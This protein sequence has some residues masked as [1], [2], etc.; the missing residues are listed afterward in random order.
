[1]AGLKTIALSFWLLAAAEEKPVPRAEPSASAPLGQLLEW[2]SSRGKPYW[3]RLPRKLDRKRPPNLLLMLHGTGLKWGWA[4]WNYPIAAGGFRGEDI[5]VAPEAMTPGQGDTFN[6]VQGGA[7]GEQLAELIGFFKRQLPV[8]KVYLYGHSQGAFFAYWFA[9][10]HPELVDGIVAHAGNVLAVKHTALA[11]QKVAIGILHA[12]AD[13]VVPVDCA[14]RSEKI[15]REEGYRRVKLEV[16]EGLT[17][18]SGHWPLPKQVGEMLSWLD[19]VTAD[20]PALALLSALQVL[21]Q[22]EPDL[23][24]VVESVKR[25]GL[26]LKAPRP[27]DPPDLLEK[28]EALKKLLDQAAHEHAEAIQAEAGAAKTEAPFGCWAGHFL[29][30]DRALGTLPAW[31]KAASG[32]RR[33]AASEEKGVA[34]ALGLLEQAGLKAL[35]EGLKALEQGFLASRYE[36]LLVR[37]ERLAGDSSLKAEERKRTEELLKSRRA[38]LLEGVKAALA[39]D[40]RLC[41]SFREAHPAWFSSP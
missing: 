24:S 14:Y 19:S 22:D 18:E 25:A 40:L 30:T 37:V 3:Y 8:G 12:R 31:Q 36:D 26:M 6:F 15:Y 39:I 13:A 38:A 29:H 28:L 1:M 33:R 16:V 7:D 35:G 9:G 20:S 11:R 21:A 27:R 10:E 32:P 17:A 34:R 2:T 5:V 4:F 41:R 23:E